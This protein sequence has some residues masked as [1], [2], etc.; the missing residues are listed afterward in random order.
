MLLTCIVVST[1]NLG[2]ED[3]TSGQDCFLRLKLLFYAPNFSI[4]REVLFAI[5]GEEEE[6]DSHVQGQSTVS[7]PT[8]INQCRKKF[9]NLF[10]QGK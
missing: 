10:S 1:D 6:D 3:L 7:L 9:W 2:N 4:S 5:C 8:K